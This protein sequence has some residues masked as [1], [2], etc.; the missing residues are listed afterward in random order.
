M[1]SS[2]G[3]GALTTSSAGSSGISNVS[4]A[5]QL[6]SGMVNL[7]LGSGAGMFARDVEKVANSFVAAAR[8][9]LGM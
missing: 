3:L 9:M 7:L 4:P 5:S 6:K 1:A 2:S 8:P